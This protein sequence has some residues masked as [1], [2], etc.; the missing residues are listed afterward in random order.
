MKSDPTVIRLRTLPAFRGHRDRD[1]RSLTSLVDRAEIPP[2]HVLTHQGDFARQ[3]F[4][5]LDGSAEVSVDGQSVA[6]IGPGDFV[7]EMAMLDGHRRSATV[8]ATSRM[9][10]LVIGPGAWSAFV[11]HPAVA[12][13]LAVQMARRL[14]CLPGGRR[15]S[16]ASDGNRAPVLPLGS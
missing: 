4:L 9:E 3:A 15:T 12:R 8:R 13:A 14:R 6:A 5:V 16:G 7:G 1:L 10:V 11:S 2:G